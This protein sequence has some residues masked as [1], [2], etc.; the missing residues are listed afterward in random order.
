MQKVGMD[1]IQNAELQVDKVMNIQTEKT[2]QTQLEVMSTI[3]SGIP[4]GADSRG[5]LTKIRLI[6]KSSLLG[7]DSAASGVHLISEILSEIK[8]EVIE[9][10]AYGDIGFRCNFRISESGK[11]K[12]E[13]FYKS[14][15]DPAL[16]AKLKWCDGSSDDICDIFDLESCP[17]F[18]FI[19]HRWAPNSAALGMHDELLYVLACAPE[20]YIWL[21]C[22]CAPQDKR[23][24]ENKN[25][26]KVIWNI[27]EILDKATS[28]L[29]YYA[30]DGLGY[31]PM[32]VILDDERRSEGELCMIS[33]GIRALMAI[34]NAALLGAHL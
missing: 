9:D 12:L 5:R 16:E 26:F 27:A 22:C 7:T 8:N 10:N 2:G 20:D 28:V 19:S 13:L 33:H 11:N 14:K 15:I 25:I 34:P 23:N 6:R 32:S 17:S 3:L 29:H 31:G 21:D 18:T 1:N 30:T 24:F 4:D